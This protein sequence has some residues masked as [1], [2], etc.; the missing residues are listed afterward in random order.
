MLDIALNSAYF[1][2]YFPINVLSVDHRL[3]VL[4]DYVLPFPS[5]HIVVAALV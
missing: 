5:Y 2:S 4:P 1:F 3:P